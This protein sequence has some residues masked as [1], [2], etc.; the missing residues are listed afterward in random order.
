LEARGESISG[1]D[2]AEISRLRASIARRTGCFA[3]AIGLL[4][5][6]LSEDAGAPPDRAR[7]LFDNLAW[8]RY[9]AGDK[10]GALVAARRALDLSSPGLDRGWAL[11]SVAVIGSEH[12]SVAERRQKLQQ[13]LAIA[14]ERGALRLLASAL[15]HLGSLERAVG[16]PAALSHF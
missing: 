14:R 4:E 16:D 6:A 1:G 13:A 15:T 10:A 7:L 5:Q 9:R 11:R 2:R 8:A 3:E 12:L